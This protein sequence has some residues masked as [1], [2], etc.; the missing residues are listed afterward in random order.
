MQGDVSD[1][2]ATPRIDRGIF[3]NGLYACDDILTKVVIGLL[4]RDI[5]AKS[6]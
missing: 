5:A 1:R 6:C 2:E 4:S 3:K